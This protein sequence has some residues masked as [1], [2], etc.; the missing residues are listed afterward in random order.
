MTTRRGFLGGV[1]FCSCGLLD[2]VL[3]QGQA[4]RHSVTGLPPERWSSLK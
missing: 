2:T 1:A 4:A 3:A